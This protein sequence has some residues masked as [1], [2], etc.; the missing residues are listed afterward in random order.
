LNKTYP[1]G[2]ESYVNRAKKLLVDSANDVNP[3]EGFV[4]SVPKGK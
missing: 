1:G 2:I 4:P 3:Y